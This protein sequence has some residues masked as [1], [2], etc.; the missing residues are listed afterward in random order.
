MDRLLIVGVIVVAA[1]VLAALV[2][3]RRPDAPTRTG[4][5][6]PDQLDRSDF[7]D[8]E[9]AWLVAMFSSSTCSTCAGAWEKVRQ[10]ASDEV[11]VARLDVEDHGDLHR[12]YHIEAVPLIVVVDHEGV[13][14]ASFLGPPSAADLWAAVAEL[15]SPG[16]V[17]P[18][19]GP[20]GPL[21]PS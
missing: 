5:T 9:V 2:Q 3:R 7:V 8:P 18:G 21:D 11:S 1:S 4:Y 13:T 12:R 16:T 6:I 14:R 20:G 15:R 10:L 19:C 17:P